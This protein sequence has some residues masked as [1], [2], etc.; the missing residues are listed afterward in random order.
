MG[1]LTCP[2]FAS[3]ALRI[4]GPMI[5]RVV[6][7]MCPRHDFRGVYDRNLVKMIEERKTGGSWFGP[8]DMTPEPRKREVEKK[9]KVQR[10]DDIQLCITM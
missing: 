3:S 5:V 6:K 1:L 10:E 8:P 2:V 4:E 7:Y 9:K